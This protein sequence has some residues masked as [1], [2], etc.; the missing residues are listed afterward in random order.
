MTVMHVHFLYV[1][2]VLHVLRLNSPPPFAVQYS[3]LINVAVQKKLV[4]A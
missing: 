1:T 2:D 4:P 3:G